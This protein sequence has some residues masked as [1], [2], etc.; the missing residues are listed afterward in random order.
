M[1]ERMVVSL[2]KTQAE[3]EVLLSII[4]QYEPDVRAELVSCG[5]G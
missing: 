1:E 2:A 5:W 4:R 3:A